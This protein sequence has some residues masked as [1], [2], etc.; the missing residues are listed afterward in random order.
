MPC[1]SGSGP[2]NNRGCSTGDNGTGTPAIS[3]N[4]GPHIPDVITTFSVLIVPLSVFT[5]VTRP[6]SISKPVAGVFAYVDKEPFSL[7]FSTAKLTTSCDLGTTRP[8]SGSHIAPR[9]ES[10]SNKGNFSLA[11]AAEI[12][13][14]FVP[15]DLPDSTFLLS[16]SQRSS[17]SFRHISSPPFLRKKP[18]SS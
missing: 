2:K 3:P 12:N 18:F 1:I 9:I 13:L 4:K 14:T 7:A 11:S 16:S 5:P 17:S 15:N 8:A 10:S 6:F